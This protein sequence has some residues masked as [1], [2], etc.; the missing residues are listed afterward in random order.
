MNTIAETIAQTAARIA[1]GQT[2]IAHVMS[3]SHQAAIQI[4]EIF[5]RNRIT[6]FTVTSSDIRNTITIERG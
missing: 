6:G 4:V 2:F 3:G 1:P 5:R